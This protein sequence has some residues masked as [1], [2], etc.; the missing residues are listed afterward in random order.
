M[1]YVLSDQEVDVRT[2]TAPAAWTGRE[3]GPGSED[4]RR[5]HAVPLDPERAEPGE[6]ALACFGSDEGVRRNKGRPGAADG[7]AA[8]RPALASMVL[9]EPLRALDAR[10]VEVAGDGKDVLGCDRSRSAGTIPAT[11]VGP[12]RDSRRRRGDEKTGGGVR[13]LACPYSAGPAPQGRAIG[14]VRASGHARPVTRP[15]EPVR[16]TPPPERSR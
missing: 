1:R 4:L 14:R 16:P 5:H 2:D 12:A 7:P 15:R 8:L 6:T 10:N 13:A 3:D 9:P 11:A